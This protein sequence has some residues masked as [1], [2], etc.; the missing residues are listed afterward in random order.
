MGG[1]EILAQLHA[2]DPQVKA[3][4][5][6]RDAEAQMMDDFRQYGFCGVLTKPY[7]VAELYDA[8]QRVLHG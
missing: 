3:L 5:S 4:L 7:T 1:R 8:L 6:G 2:I